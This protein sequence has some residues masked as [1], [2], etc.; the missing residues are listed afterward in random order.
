MGR[1]R[2]LTAGIT[3]MLIN[4]SYAC[5]MKGGPM[6]LAKHIRGEVH[7]AQTYWAVEVGITLV[8]A[9]LAARMKSGWAVASILFLFAAVHPAWT[10][11]ASQGDCG[12]TL[13]ETSK[14][15]LWVSVACVV[16]QMVR[17]LSTSKLTLE[18]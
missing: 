4:M 14:I 10:V 16:L 5:S 6:A 17:W 2:T 1:I 7:N 8:M 13:R 18:K 9:I 3:M 12:E 11:S 15:L